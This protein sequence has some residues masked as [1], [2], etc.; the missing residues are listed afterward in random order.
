MGKDYKKSFIFILSFFTLI[1]LYKYSVDETKFYIPEIKKTYSGRIIDKY[2]SHSPHLQ[3][4]AKTNT[5]DI[6]NVSDTL[7]KIAKV[8]DSIYKPPNVNHIILYKNGREFKLEY[9]F[10]PFSVIESKYWPKELDY[11]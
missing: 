5:I 4:L 7:M 8:G 1:I 2:Y 6:F 3:I 9:M 11:K 10:I